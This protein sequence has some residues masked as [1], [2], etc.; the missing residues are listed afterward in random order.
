MTFGIW[1]Q[2][3]LKDIEDVEEFKYRRDIPPIYKALI[4]GDYDLVKWYIDSEGVDPN[5]AVR[6]KSIYGRTVIPMYLYLVYHGK[7][8]DLLRYLFDHPKFKYDWDFENSPRIKYLSLNLIKHYA[9]RFPNQFKKDQFI[10]NY[11]NETTTIEQLNEALALFD[12]PITVTSNM[13]GNNLLFHTTNPILFE[14]LLKSGLNT[15]IIGRWNYTLLMQLISYCN[16]KDKLSCIELL[17]QY[18]ANVNITVEYLCIPITAVDFILR[19]NE[20]RRP[21]IHKVLKL[22]MDNNAKANYQYYLNNYVH[23]RELFEYLKD[24]LPHKKNRKKRTLL[25]LAVMMNNNSNNNIETLL[26]NGY[27]PNAKDRFGNTPLHYAITIDSI[28]SLLKYGANI[29]TRNNMGETPLFILRRKNYIYGRKYAYKPEYSSR[30][31]SAYNIWHQNQIEIIERKVMIHYLL[32]HGA[33]LYLRPFDVKLS[34][35]IEN[36]LGNFVNACKEY[37]LSPD[38]MYVK[39][40]LSKH[41]SKIII[42]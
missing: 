29:N 42:N 35:V 9:N 33:K 24:K 28:K 3:R 32:E 6:R 40:I 14:Y 27:D 1:D 31:E 26:I 21:N 4:I 39:K 34:S 8:E 22:L 20:H 12:T 11:I 7:G 2:A 25:H 38:S 41:D 37:I 30:R 18:G 13:H 19:F 16:K 36:N 17:I 15:N 23:N 5:I 10:F